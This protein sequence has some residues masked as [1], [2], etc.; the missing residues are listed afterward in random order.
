MGHWHSTEKSKSYCF[1][2]RYVYVR[3]INNH[4]ISEKGLG[5]TNLSNF[6]CIGIVN[7]E[8]ILRTVPNPHLSIIFSIFHLHTAEL[9]LSIQWRLFLHHSLP[10]YAYDYSKHISTTYF[11]NL[12]NTYS[13]QNFAEYLSRNQIFPS[14]IYIVSYLPSAEAV[15]FACDMRDWIVYRVYIAWTDIFFKL[16]DDVVE[17]NLAYKR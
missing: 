12:W 3:K 8:F 4:L 9:Y 17:L 10:T 13:L 16:V 7:I 14:K 2:T 11:A 6:F 1:F 5:R 15:S